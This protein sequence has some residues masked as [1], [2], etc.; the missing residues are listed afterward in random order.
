ML[1]YTMA[2][3]LF[4][5]QKLNEHQF[6]LHSD[7]AKHCIKS[8]RHRVNDH[9]YITDFS[10]IIY[11]GKILS[12][13]LSHCLISIEEI[14]IENPALPKVNVAI[15]PCSHPDRLEWFIEKS[16]EVGVH[17]IHLI[18]C[19]RTEKPFVKMDRLQ[20]LCMA[21]SKQTLRPSLPIIFPVRPFSEF[22]QNSESPIKLLC[23]CDSNFNKTALR[24]NLIP[25]LDVVVAI[26]PEGDFSREEIMFSM[27]QG[28]L[29]SDL[30]PQR[31][32]TETAGLVATSIIQEFNFTH[33]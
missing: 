19:S 5:G 11:I 33:S 20:K 3:S 14:A 9:I 16:T 12:D 2:L 21:A 28:F 13:D 22:C 29:L 25:S 31:L 23:H 6:V 17:E 26:G 10:G 4:C 27:S 18:Q 8:T 1:K 15:S 30:G 24:N 7:D 32:R